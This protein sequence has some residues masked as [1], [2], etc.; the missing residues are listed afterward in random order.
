LKQEWQKSPS[1]TRQTDGKNMVWFGEIERKLPNYQ[2]LLLL[3]F[4]PLNYFMPPSL[5]QMTHVQ[6]VNDDISYIPL[7]IS[8]MSVSFKEDT[9][10]KYILNRPY[11]GLILVSNLKFLP[12]CW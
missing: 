11:L 4:L 10:T 6:M 3:T 8:F 2:R 1:G 9:Y 7:L 5:Q 12:S